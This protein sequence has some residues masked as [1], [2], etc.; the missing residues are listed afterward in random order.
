MIFW[1]FGLTIIVT[2]VVIVV[3]LV[4]VEYCKRWYSSDEDD[5]TTIST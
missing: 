5:K 4:S 1:R 2:V 3:V